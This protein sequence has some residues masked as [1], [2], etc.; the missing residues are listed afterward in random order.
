MALLATG[1]VTDGVVFAA[2]LAVAVVLSFRERRKK[3]RSVRT[4]ESALLGAQPRV[5]SRRTLILYPWYGAIVVLANVI[6]LGTI[7]WWALIGV[8]PLDLVVL[9]VYFWP[10]IRVSAG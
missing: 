7:G 5:R 10:G 6:P 2:L 8:V 3:R 4:A 1:W 9:Y